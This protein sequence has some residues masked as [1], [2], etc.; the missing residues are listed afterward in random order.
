MK[1]QL[2]I[3]DKIRPD[4]SWSGSPEGIEVV[5][6]VIEAVVHVVDSVVVEVVVDEDV[7]SV[8]VVVDVEVEVVVL[9]WQNQTGQ[10]MYDRVSVSHPD[11]WQGIWH[12]DEFVWT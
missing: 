4:L 7:L 8:V 9:S 1:T 2:K 10:S 6:L 12:C 11:N 5:K 3:N